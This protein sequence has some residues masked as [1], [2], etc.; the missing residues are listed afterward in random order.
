MKEKQ[1]YT[2]SEFCE[3]CKRYAVFEQVGVNTLVC[4]NCGN[5]VP[6]HRIDYFSVLAIVLPAIFFVWVCWYLTGE[7]PTTAMI[8]VGIISL[9]LVIFDKISLNWIIKD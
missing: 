8:I 1:I 4:R 6:K 7:F 5:D 3:K 9:L 2:R